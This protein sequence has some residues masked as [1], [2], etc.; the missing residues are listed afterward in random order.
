[1]APLKSLVLASILALSATVT[2]NHGP[3]M[4]LYARNFPSGTGAPYPSGTGTGYSYGTGTGV[5]PYPTG[6]SPGSGGSGSGPGSGPG[7]ASVSEKAATCPL[8]TTVTTTTQVYVT[9][10]VG[11]PPQAASTAGL[12]PPYSIPG[13][14]VGPIGGTGTGTGVASTGVAQPTGTGAFGKRMEMRGLER[15]EKKRGHFWA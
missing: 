6:G 2:A 10:T 1:M 5:V 15:K 11:G 13:G 12:S 7:G 3:Y 14:G 9:V 8:P 4:P